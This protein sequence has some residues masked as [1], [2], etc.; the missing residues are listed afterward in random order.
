MFEV[1]TASPF[2]CACVQIKTAVSCLCLVRKPVPSSH[3]FSTDLARALN[4]TPL[5]DGIGE[6]AH[7]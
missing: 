5:G 1:T 3:V 7:T 6:L 2:M 4:D